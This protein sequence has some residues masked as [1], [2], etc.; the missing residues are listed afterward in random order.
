M[1]QYTVPLAGMGGVEFVIQ[2]V[3]SEHLAV[4]F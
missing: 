3:V 1:G 4:H 2:E